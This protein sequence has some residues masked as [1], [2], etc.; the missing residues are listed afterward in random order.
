MKKFTMAGIIQ[1]EII[2]ILFEYLHPGML[3]LNKSNEQLGVIGYIFKAL[4]K[5]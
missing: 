3:H 4:R 1:P 2:Q 5:P